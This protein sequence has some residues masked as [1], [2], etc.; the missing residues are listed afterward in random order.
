MVAITSALDVCL[1]SSGI[2]ELLIRVFVQV[3]DRK[4]DTALAL[5]VHIKRN[6]ESW[7]SFGY[8]RNIAH[9]IKQEIQKS[10]SDG[11]PGQ[12]PTRAVPQLNEAEMKDTENMLL[13]LLRGDST[14]FSAMSPIA[15]SI[16][17]AWKKVDLDLCT[18]GNPVRESQA[19][20]TYR[21]GHRSSWD[22]TSMATPIPRGLGSR[23]LQISWPRDKPE[24][25]IDALG[26][27]RAL[28]SDMTKAWQ[29]G[30]DAALL[31]ELVGE[32]D[33]PYGHAT[34]VYYSFQIP[35]VARVHKRYDPH[36]GMLADQG[37][38][39]D[40]EKTHNA[41]EEIVMGEPADSLRW[42]HSHVAQDYL[43]K[44]DNIDVVREPEFNSVYF[45]YQ[46]FIFGFYYQL[47]QKLLSFDLVE[48]AA[49]F[50]GI[51]GT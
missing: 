50:H 30:K 6:I 40:T 20:V 47:L 10:L 22:L 4:D 38:P 33:G 36:I 29:Y 18:D 34:E 21:A 42:L 48:T 15:F 27:K 1:P 51:W 35:D 17:E 41:L 12:L 44:V 46:A 45:K 39:V 9:S 32:A 43:V 8:A 31:L 25:M 7:R 14:V 37:I 23:A 2:Q 28:V 49:F 24:S 19:C 16:A 11:V 13:W 5:R 26:V 3:L